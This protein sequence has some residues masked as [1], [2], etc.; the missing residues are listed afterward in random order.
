MRQPPGKLRLRM[1]TALWAQFTWNWLHWS[2]GTLCL[3]VSHIKAFWSSAL[4][5]LLRACKNGHWPKHTS[6]RY[7]AIWWS[8]HLKWFFADKRQ[9]TCHL[10]APD[11][12]GRC[13]GEVGRDVSHATCCCTLGRG[14]TDP[15]GRC[16]ACPVNDSSTWGTAVPLFILRVSYFC[17]YIS[18]SS[19]ERLSSL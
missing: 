19:R 11:R 8:R 15:S 18:S 16:Q 3:R 4:F 1:S 2:V 7:P 5:W 12:R 6:H 9:G 14:W 17:V 13:V 10:Q